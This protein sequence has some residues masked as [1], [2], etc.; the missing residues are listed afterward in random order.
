M[1]FG[2][3]LHLLQIP[4]C[5]AFGIYM[6]LKFGT[7]RRFFASLWIPAASIGTSQL[8]YM[9]PASLIELARGRRARAMGIALCG[10]ITLLLN[11]ALVLLA[12]FFL[13]AQVGR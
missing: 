7:S 8:I 1:R 10:L 5:L 4:I 3:K 11:V 9:I 13:N 12:F 2:A 6:A